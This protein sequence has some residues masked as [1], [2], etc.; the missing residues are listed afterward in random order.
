MRMFYYRT[1]DEVSNELWHS[2][3]NRRDLWKYM[4]S[5]QNHFKGDLYRQLSK[6]RKIYDMDYQKFKDY[7]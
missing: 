1:E 2:V 3:K 6:I 4:K 7:Y 5:I